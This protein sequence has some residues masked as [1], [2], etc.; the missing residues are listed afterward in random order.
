LR[1]V[2]DTNLVVS[3]LLWNGRPAS[4]IEAAEDK[5]IEL[6]TT[7]ALLCELWDVL[8]RAKFVKQLMKRQRTAQGVLDDYEVLAKIVSPAAIL[9]AIL[10]D[11]AD[12]HVLAAALGGKV[13]LIVSGDAHSLDMKRYLG[14]PIVTASEAVARIDP[15]S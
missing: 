4:L 3:G 6:V 15:M 1:L 10:R 11:P 12:D 5:D 14:I 9:P 7:A 13:D 2:L 8:T